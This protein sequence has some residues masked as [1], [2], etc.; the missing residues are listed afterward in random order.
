MLTDVKF[1][2]PQGIQTAGELVIPEAKVYDA[3]SNVKIYEKR[4]IFIQP[5]Q[6]EP[7]ADKA[8]IACIVTYQAC[9]ETI[10]IPPVTERV[11]VINL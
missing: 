3:D 6:V 1:E 5:I 4:A 9:D 10:C 8:K 11:E 2:Y 7:K